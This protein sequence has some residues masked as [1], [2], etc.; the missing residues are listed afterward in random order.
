MPPRKTKTTEKY[1]E[2]RRFKEVKLKKPMKVDIVKEN[3]EYILSVRDFSIF[4]WGTSLL[5]VQEEIKED[6]Y[7]LYSS[8]F[9]E[10]K[11]LGEPMIEMKENFK[12][13]LYAA[14]KN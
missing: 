11:N 2:L 7:Y 14:K 6:M 9:L 10:N 12:K 4:A 1:W 8:L 13:Y 3:S 5:E